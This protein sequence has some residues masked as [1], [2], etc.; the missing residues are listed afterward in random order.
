M[1]R[2]AEEAITNANRHGLAQNVSIEVKR[3]GASLIV[4]VADDG[5][6][7]RVGEPGL[8]SALFDEVSQGNWKLQPQL[9]GGSLLTVHINYVH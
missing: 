3:D 2:V 1:L 9:D 6:G 8:G 7:L 5:M 4:T